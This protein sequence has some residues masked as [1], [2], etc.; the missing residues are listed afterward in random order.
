MK[1]ALAYEFQKSCSAYFI[2]GMDLFMYQ[3]TGLNHSCSLYNIQFV[4]FYVNIS[5]KHICIHFSDLLFI[6]RK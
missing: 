6:F 3:I 5:V 4:G 2:S 1:V